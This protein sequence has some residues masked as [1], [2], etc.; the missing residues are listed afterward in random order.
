MATWAEL[1]VTVCRTNSGQPDELPLFEAA[2]PADNEAP[3]ETSVD[4]IRQALGT[5]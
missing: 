1:K 2:F 4:N 3:E 5:K